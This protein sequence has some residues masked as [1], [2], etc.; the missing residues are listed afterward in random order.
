LLCIHDLHIAFD[1]AAVVEDVSLDVQQGERVALVGESGSGKT[2]TALAV[3]GLVQGAQLKGSIRWQG[4]EWLGQSERQWCQVRGS[5]VAM[6]FQEPMTAL[7]PVL[8]IGRQLAEVLELKQGLMLNNP[9][10]SAIDLIASV[11]LPEPEAK[12]R[13]YPHQL[14]GGQR[15]RVVIAMALAAQPKLLLADEPT[16]ALDVNLRQQMLDLLMAQQTARGMAVVL[17]SH[18]LPLVRRFAQRVVV[19]QQGRIV[20]QGLVAEVFAHPQH[21]YT[22]RLLDS[23]PQRDPQ[24]IPPVIPADAV[25]RVAVQQ[26]AVAY[27]VP[28]AGWRGWFRSAQM[29]VLM[30]TDLLLH[31]GQT[32]AV[33]GESGSGKSTLAL[34]VLEL[35]GSTAVV[36]GEI[37]LTDRAWSIDR[38]ERRRQR[39]Q[40]QVV[41]QD[42]FSSLSPRLTIAEV[43]GEGLEVHAPEL[44]A[45]ARHARVVA[46]LREVGLLPPDAT[47]LDASP[48]LQRYPHQFS[49]G[50]RQRLAIARAL[51]VDPDVL[52]LDEPTS[53]LDVTVQQQVLRLLQALQR[54][55]GLSY[56]LITH[57]MAVVQAMAHQV[58]VL[59][60]G[61][62]VETGDVLQVLT[63]PRD[64]YTRLL[65]ESVV[66]PTV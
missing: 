2:L 39:K 28:R 50:Q 35:L 45:S 21:P 62:V 14:S 61:R 42:P 23:H 12:A 27:Q 3:M 5:E 63:Q 43:V 66:A 58:V 53:A 51:I 24:A 8:T 9:A 38:R 32:V 46:V 20:E 47:P 54:E 22:R 57:D 59:Q 60:A 55:R 40:V 10:Q 25:P 17:I 64:P 30:P 15:Q 31:R 33:V 41:F 11:G 4:Q 26:L 56:L 1:G 34:A 49:G 18:D 16:T 19:M 44:S 65:V 29:P 6:V 48:L 7:N 37:R 36:Q 52:V 13:A